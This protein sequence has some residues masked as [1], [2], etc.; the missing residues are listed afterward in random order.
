MYVNLS[1]FE[2]DKALSCLN[3]SQELLKID[4]EL[5]GALGKRTKFQ[6]HDIAQLDVKVFYSFL[7]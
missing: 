3:K 1:Y 5:S 2:Y 7:V 6:E 4:I